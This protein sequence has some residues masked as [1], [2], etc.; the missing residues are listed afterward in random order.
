M[1]GFTL[2]N[3]LFQHISFWSPCEH[4]PRCVYLNTAPPHNSMSGHVRMQLAL[5]FVQREQTKW[6]R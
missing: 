1:T 6:L 4:E 2:K 3:I 5:T